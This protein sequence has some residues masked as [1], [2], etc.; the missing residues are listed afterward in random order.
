MSDIRLEPFA[1]RITW[2]LDK[3][4]SGEEWQTLLTTYLEKLGKFGTEQ[5]NTI[6]GHIKGI[7]NFSEG[8]FIQVSVISTNRSATTTI[9]LPDDFSTAR[10]S[11][12]LNYLVYGL[13]YEDASRISQITAAE[14]AKQAGGT[15]EFM[16]LSDPNQADHHHQ[17]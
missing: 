12:T 14:L 5:P 9:Q 3:Q 2:Q 8:E 1:A 10:L 15:A 16:M 6:I 11:F 7:A 4:L 17:H 13:A